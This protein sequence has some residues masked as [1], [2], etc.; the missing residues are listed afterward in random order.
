VSATIE[1]VAKA[2]GVSVAT[3]SRALRGLPN[4][5]PSTRDRVLAAAGELQYVAHPQASRLAARRSLTIGLVVPMLGQWYYAQLFSGVEAELAAA[6]YDVLPYTL[7][8]PAGVDGFLEHLPYRKR[9]DG[10]IVVDAPLAEDEVERIASGGLPTL[11]VGFRRD[12]VPSLTVDNVGAARL[13]VSHLTGLGHRR[14][15]M[16][17]GIEDDPFHFSVP[18]DRRR[19][20]F[21][22]L[23][24][25][26]LSA[27]PALIAPGNFS[28]AGGV[29]AMHRLLHLPSPPTAVFACSDEM[30]IGAMQ[31]ARDAGRSVP[32]DLSIVGFDDHD[33]SEY[34]G[35][36]TIRQDVVELG[37]RAAALLLAQ[38]QGEPLEGEERH[39][40]H[41]TRLVVRRSTA[42][43]GGLVEAGSAVGAPGPKTLA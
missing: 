26:G 24:A 18:V 3:V 13:A 1:D 17:G 41:P 7:S 28:L 33:V 21:D 11:T 38:L 40:V 16:I 43:P 30:A 14:I 19:G 12:D 6:G 10:L 9:V 23:A 42:P 31:V 2:A 39:Q 20:Y 25:V 34:L 4:V 5:A 8:G 32:G 22:A 15:A 37:E 35:L 27:E 36:T 29:D